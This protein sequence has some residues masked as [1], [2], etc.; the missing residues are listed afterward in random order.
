MRTGLYS[1]GEL[2]GNRHIEQLVIPE[3]QR[4]Y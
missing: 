1:I 2:F 4:D 3:I